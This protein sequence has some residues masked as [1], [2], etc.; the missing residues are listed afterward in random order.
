MKSNQN[1]D[2]P[3]A[4]SNQDSDTQEKLEEEIQNSTKDSESTEECDIVELANLVANQ[5]KADI[6]LF[7][8]YIQEDSFYEVVKAVSPDRTAKNCILMITTYGGSAE[9][10]FKI[11]RWLQRSYQSLVVYPTSICA[12]AGTL[13]AIGASKL[14]MSPVSQLGP[15]DVQ[16]LKPNELGVR[17]SGMVSKST[18]STL[19]KSA[20]QFW[21]YFTLEIKD[22]S[23]GN[24]AFETCAEIGA[25]IC[26]SV[27]AEIY[28]QIDPEVLGENERDLLVA[29]EY[30]R[31]LAKWS[32]NITETE[33]ER[34]VQGYVSHKFVIDYEEASELFERV[35][36]PNVELS[37]LTIEL[38][39]AAFSTQTDRILVNRLVTYTQ[40][41]QRNETSSSDTGNDNQ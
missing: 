20:F 2:T 9:A 27:F 32:E 25:T 40:G 35:V 16:L 11:T 8:G 18:L 17:K 1:S 22:R 24:I 23:F 41:D 37:N 26:S 7:N 3:Q 38:G 12:S 6:Y 14:I 5:E 15:L 36:K 29:F 28:K 21:Q 33:I 39:K 31:R 34:L 13:I 30:G 10:A 19:E 4:E